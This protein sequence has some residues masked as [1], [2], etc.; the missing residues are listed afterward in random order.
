M[1]AEPKVARRPRTHRRSEAAIRASWFATAGEL[2]R[3]SKRRRVWWV[4]QCI[5]GRVAWGWGPE[6]K[7]ATFRKRLIDVADAERLLREE[8]KMQAPARPSTVVEKMSFRKAMDEF[9]KKVRAGDLQG[10]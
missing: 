2:A 4:E 3:I 6:I 5:A 8:M 9:R 10:L 1:S 7:N